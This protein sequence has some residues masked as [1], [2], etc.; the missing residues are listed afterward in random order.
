MIVCEMGGGRDLKPQV[1]SMQTP[2]MSS[3]MRHGNFHKTLPAGFI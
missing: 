3:K 1:T 2:K